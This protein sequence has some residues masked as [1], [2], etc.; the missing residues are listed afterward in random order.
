MHKRGHIGIRDPNVGG[1]IEHRPYEV[2]EVAGVWCIAV[3]L[4]AGVIREMP[5][6][7]SGW[8][9]C[10]I[11]KKVTRA[12][13]HLTQGVGCGTSCGRGYQQRTRRDQRP[14]SG[15]FYRIRF[16]EEARTDPAP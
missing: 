2:V 12:Y 13:E 3:H 5:D 14:A 9:H 6:G 16:P 15:R 1:R 11:D 7:E 4:E 10:E 8:H